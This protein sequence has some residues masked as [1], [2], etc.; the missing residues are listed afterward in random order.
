MRAFCFLILSLCFSTFAHTSEIDGK[1]QGYIKLFNLRPLSAPA[2]INRDLFRLGRDLFFEKEISGNKN[3]SCADCHHPMVMTHDGLPLGI[4]EGAIGIEA[5]TPG[6]LQKTGKILARN[7]PALFNLHNVPVMFWDGRVTLG[8]DGKWS[9]PS[10]LPEKFAAVLDSALSAQALFPMANHDEMSGEPG[11]NEIADAKTDAQAWEAIFKRLYAIEDYRVR[12][13]ALFPGE[14]LNLAHVAKA[15][16]HFEAQ[17]FY[18]ADTSYDRYLQGDKSA[19]TEIQKMGMDVFFG[20]G[21]CGECHTGEHLSDFSFHNVGIPQIGPGKNKGDD[22]GRLE[23]DGKNENVYAF[24]V[25]ALRNVAMTGPYMHNGTFKTL[26]QI[27]EHYDDI[28]SSLN[29]YSW[30]NNYKNYLSKITGPLPET[31]EFKLG[32]LSGKL[33]RKLNFEETEEK[34]LVEFL[35]GALTEKRFLEAEISGDY[36]TSLRIQLTQEGF[37]KILKN[38]P[39][40]GQV[41]ESNYFYFDV[42]TANGYGLRELEKPIKI[43]FIQNETGTQLNYRKQL[44][45]TSSVESG[46]VGGGTFEDEELLS[47]NTQLSDELATLNG[48][49]F[50]RLYRYYNGQSSRDIPAMEL[51]VMEKDVE[52]MN[53]LWHGLNFKRLTTMSDELNIGSSELFFA[54]TS[55]NSK[56]EYTWTKSIDNQ[57]AQWV[58][59]K[60]LLRTE[61]GSKV[62]TWALEIKLDKLTK[63]QFSS[64]V[65]AWLKEIVSYGLESRDAQGSTPSPSKLTEKILKDMF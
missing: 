18:A 47:L 29:N 10:V 26:A 14:E 44:F 22:L 5:Q 37:Y 31:N 54:P 45:K 60:S 8:P 11:T 62:E 30:V 7:T 28:E 48:D 52:A 57:K 35:R 51:L 19:M 56:L 34:A 46:V 17:A 58:L 49:F 25:P 21:K 32:H 27:I 4:G 1:L 9:T 38:I 53:K 41:R 55:S 15:I 64:A 42:L 40:L 59:Q 20:K 6:R 24:R 39:G 23:V 12:L 63:K 2:K 43:F 50:D 16:G 33:S 65:K 3:I 61:T 36:I 13:S